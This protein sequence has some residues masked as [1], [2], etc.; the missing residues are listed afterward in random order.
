MASALEEELL[1]GGGEG[2]V[3]VCCYGRLLVWLGGLALCPGPHTGARSTRVFE[4]VS[5]AD[6][7]LTGLLLGLPLCVC[8]CAVPFCSVRKPS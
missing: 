6:R 2:Q 1:L 7:Q 3:S 8:A 5:C 4:G